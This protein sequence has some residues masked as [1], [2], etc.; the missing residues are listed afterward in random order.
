MG[1]NLYEVTGSDIRVRCCFRCCS[2]VLGEESTFFIGEMWPKCWRVKFNAIRKLQAVMRMTWF[3]LVFVFRYK[4]P[5][6]Y[7]NFDWN[8]MMGLILACKTRIQQFRRWR[9]LTSPRLTRWLALREEY[10]IRLD[11]YNLALSNK[12]FVD[13]SDLMMR[14][15]IISWRMLCHNSSSQRETRPYWFW[16]RGI[17]HLGGRTSIIRPVHPIHL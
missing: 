14:P 5:W 7:S 9:S 2:G 3:R 13:G 10:R 6:L 4:A 1:C 16:S 11:F 8:K 17:R 15:L 12:R